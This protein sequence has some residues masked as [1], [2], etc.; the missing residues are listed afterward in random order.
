MT[1]LVIGASGATGR[2][3]VKQLLEQKQNVRAVVRT[4]SVI[5]A[6]FKDSPLIEI[7]YGTV[8]EMDHPQIVDLVSDCDSIVSCL[9]HN[10]DIKGIFGHPRRLVS[11]TVSR[12]CDA[13]EQRKPASPV[14]FVLM[15]TSGNQ[16]KTE[17]EQ[18]NLAHRLVIALLRATLPPH[19]DNEEAAD[20]LQNLGS[21]LIDWVAVRPDSL[22]DSE[23]VTPYS[24]HRSP[25]RDPIFN[26]GQTSR[27]N[28]AH[29]MAQLVSNDGAWRNWRRKMPVI[30]N[31]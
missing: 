25:V 19:A 27:I 7:V 9:G 3:V 31:Q 26:S 28:V 11:N 17:N 14:R 21:P 5:P 29:F 24:I 16:N 18:V 2:L 13:I 4:H 22:V 30:Y 12:L 20:H 10:P 1:T 8:L 23:Q 6:Y 15:N